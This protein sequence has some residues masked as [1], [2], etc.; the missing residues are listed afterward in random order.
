LEE[1]I[2]GGGLVIWGGGGLFGE[3]IWERV[4]LYREGRV[5]YMGVIWG[6]GGLVMVS[7]MGKGRVIWGGGLVIWGRDRGRV[8][9]YV[10]KVEA[11]TLGVRADIERVMLPHII[12]ITSTHL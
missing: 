5:C 2:W 4:K 1:G 8:T 3:G 9:C 12:I 10:G 7:Y 11:S 6:G